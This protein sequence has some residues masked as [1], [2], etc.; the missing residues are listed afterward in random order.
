MYKPM[1][2]ISSK[3]RLPLLEPTSTD[4]RVGNG[5]SNAIDGKIETY[6]ALKGGVGDG[7]WQAR[8]EPT[9]TV[10]GAAR[11]ARRVKVTSAPV[12]EQE[13]NNATI[14]VGDAGEWVLVGTLP[15]NVKKSEVY[16]FEFDQVAGN[17]TRI[18]TG[19]DDKKLAFA[20]VEVHSNNYQR[21]GCRCCGK[22][23][24]TGEFKRT[25]EPSETGWQL[26]DP[27]Q[28]S[29][30]GSLTGKTL[31]AT[32][33]ACPP[34]ERAQK[35]GTECGPDL[36]S[37]AQKLLEDGSCETCPKHSTR[38]TDGKS[39]ECVDYTESV[40]DAG[41]GAQECRVPSCAWDA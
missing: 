39:C 28:P 8:F 21:G 38:S 26:Y 20:H 35:A 30:D 14:Y 7:Y 16:T 9:T 32:C 36:C 6:F 27:V 40:A 11:G 12:S 22:D 2:F 41:T 18:R 25:E 1:D 33:K 5:P 3:E 31:A 10:L 15:D 24:R 29:G 13:L 4:Y 23:D 17:S 34:F 37:T 19:R